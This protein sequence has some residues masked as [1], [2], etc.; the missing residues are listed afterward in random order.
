MPLGLY[1]ETDTWLRGRPALAAILSATFLLIVYLVLVVVATPT[2]PAGVALRLAVSAN[3][4]FL[5]GITLAIALQAYLFAYGRGIA[6]RLGKTNGIGTSSSV[7][8]SF[9]SFF[10]LTNVGC[11]GLLP[12]WI[13]IALGGGATATGVSVFL[14]DNSTPLTVLGLGLTGV[15]ILFAFRNIRNSLKR[16]AE[17]RIDNSEAPKARRI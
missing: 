14:I 4:P 1:G 3:W 5:A 2:I 16:L 9:A 17:P 10:G 12:L 7:L 11:C 15:A 6:C 8:A 13:S